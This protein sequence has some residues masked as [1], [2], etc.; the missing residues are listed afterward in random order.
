LLREFNIREHLAFAAAAGAAG[1]GYLT[2]EV[3]SSWD[4]IRALRWGAHTVL[5]LGLAT[6]VQSTMTVFEGFTWGWLLRRLGVNA[7]ARR[8]VSAFAISQ[9]AKYLPGNVGQHVGRVAFARKEGWPVTLVIVSMLLENGFAVGTGAMVVGSALFERLGGGAG[10]N[11]RLLVL[12]LVAGFVVGVLVIRR[13]LAAPPAF[14]RSRLGE[15][16]SV[17]LAT[18]TLAAY[19]AVHLA[20][21]AALGAS[22]ALCLM[23]VAGRVPGPFWEVPAAATASWLFGYLVPGAPAG[24]G[25]RESG[26]IAL[27]GTTVGPGVVVAAAVTWR[28]TGLLADSVVL[29]TGLVLQT[30]REPAEPSTS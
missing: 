25:V 7:G 10:G 26:L 20:S 15:S 17:S 21:C 9:F 12:L 27:L 24:L 2:Y 23:S 30:S 5:W 19:L 13:V 11:A 4:Q 6:V 16:Q 3:W 18:G 8:A 28:I 22:F 14:L 1:I 29:L